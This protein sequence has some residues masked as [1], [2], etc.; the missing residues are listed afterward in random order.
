M[1]SP[2]SLPLPLLLSCYN[3]T[4]VLTQVAIMKIDVEGQECYVLDAVLEAVRSGKVIHN[5]LVEL[6]PKWW[7]SPAL[8]DTVV[9][10]LLDHGPE[11]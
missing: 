6:T 1:H 5:L 9:Q 8:C 10:G 7:S 2:L 3:I 4:F 11:S